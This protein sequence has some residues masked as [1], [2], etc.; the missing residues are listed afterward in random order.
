M[1]EQH[2]DITTYYIRTKN[3]TRKIVSY[4]SD[5]CEL[6]NTHL[7]INNFLERRFIPSIFSKGY[8]K[9]RSIYHN[10]QSHM[11]NDYFILMDIKDFF[12]SICHKQLAQK[13]FY[14]INL[15]KSNQINLL[16]CYKLISLCSIDSRGLPLGFITS[17][18]LS[19]I[20]L[21]DFDNIFYGKLKELNLDNIIYTRYADDLTVSYKT[22][23]TVKDVNME[24][25]IA[26]TASN[27][28]K[29]YGL[30]L[31]NRKTRSINLNVSNHV[32]ITGVNITK[33]NYNFRHLTVGRSIKNQLY[34]DALKCIDSD[35]DLLKNKVKGMLS[36]VLSIE[37]AGFETCYSDLMMAKVYSLGFSSLA[38]LI[39]SIK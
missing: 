16:E 35:N 26:E 19:N 36:F 27:I 34:W 31:N 14:E 24:A 2:P 11:Y 29:R 32:R 4:I 7:K 21:K 8:I 12:H 38:E 28:L 39:M 17:P 10:A 23:S 18:I 33:N 22:K 5:D 25:K 9:N 1:N 13:I 30:K 3:K 15:T 37:K 20:Y 6:R